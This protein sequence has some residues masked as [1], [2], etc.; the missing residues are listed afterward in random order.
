MSSHL[1][2]L[3]VLYLKKEVTLQQ[4]SHIDTLINEHF[5]RDLAKADVVG[6][7]ISSLMIFL[8]EIRRSWGNSVLLRIDMHEWFQQ[9]CKNTTYEA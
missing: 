4:T 6:K 3:F 1:R 8:Q 5:A 7:S 9:K 2:H